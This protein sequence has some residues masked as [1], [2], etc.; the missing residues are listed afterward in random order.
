MTII[1]EI[2]GKCKGEWFKGLV[3]ILG[4]GLAFGL[5]RLSMTTDP[6][7]AI[8]VTAPTGSTLASPVSAV[9]AKTNKSN[10]TNSKISGEGKVV[11][12]REGSKYHLPTCSG[13]KR[14]KP[15]NLVEYES[16]AAAEAAGLTAAANCPGL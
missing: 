13:A 4:L 2:W 11:A 5:G 9:T 12:S 16:V 15:E 10:L 14:I 1:Q 8:S 7:S 3:F 6:K